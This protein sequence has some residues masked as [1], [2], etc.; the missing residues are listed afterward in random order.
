MI[1]DQL[2]LILF[3]MLNRKIILESSTNAA[4]KTADA[5]LSY[6]LSGFVHFQC[7]SMATCKVIH[8]GNVNIDGSDTHSVHKLR[9]ISF[10]HGDIFFRDNFSK[11]VSL[12]SKEV[13]NCASSCVELFE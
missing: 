8:Q 11:H 5:L 12:H 9:T 2:K 7:C 3:Q 4:F 6:Q 13:S 10:S 1:E